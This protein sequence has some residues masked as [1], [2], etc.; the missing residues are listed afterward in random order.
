MPPRA[1][2][3]FLLD[4][5]MTPG[6]KSGYRLLL[7]WEVMSLFEGCEFEIWLSLQELASEGDD[8]ATEDILTSLP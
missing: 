8:Y 4:I 2:A 6:L 5:E 1:E 7:I 3:P